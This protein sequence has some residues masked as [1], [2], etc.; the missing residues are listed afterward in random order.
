MYDSTVKLS[1]SEAGHRYR[2]S[3]R[4]DDK[5]KWSDPRPTT[6]VTTILNTLDKPALVGWSARLAVEDYTKRLK[7]FDG[8][9]TAG[10]MADIESSA[11]NAHV[12]ARESAG[13]L[14]TRI[15][16]LIEAF[17]SAGDPDKWIPDKDEDEKVVQAVNGYIEDWEKSEHKMLLVEQPI[18]SLKH[19]YA[20][21][22]DQMV[23]SSTGKTIL[24]DIKTSKVSK[25]APNGAYVEMFAQ[26]GGYAQALREMFGYYPDELEIVNVGKEDGIIR[27]TSSKDFGMTVEDA[28]HYWLSI[29]N[30]WYTNKDWE[31]KFKRS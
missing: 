28:I 19:D 10:V 5:E 31:W 3:F 17:H 18:Y 20:G 11:K 16:S 13:D 12:E 7:T 26:L 25:W 14:G 2:V 29:H 22:L 27:K 23:R 30:T 21:T 24:R 8:K 1:F 15:H 9:L 4:N 6:G